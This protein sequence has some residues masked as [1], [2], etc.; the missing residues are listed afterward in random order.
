MS[1]RAPQ[2]A[3]DPFA[4]LALPAAVHKQA[5]R[6]L[7][8][9]TQARTVAD[10]VHATDRA[11]GF[12]LGIETV[13]ALNLGAIEGLYLVFDRASQARQTELEK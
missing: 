11:E 2:A 8:G 9:I 3:D 5:S 13:R 1:N 4:A 7:A 12:T 10:T 6:L